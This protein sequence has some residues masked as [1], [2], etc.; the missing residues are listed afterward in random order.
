MWFI[1]FISL[2]SGA[3]VSQTPIP[4]VAGNIAGIADD[5]RAMIACNKFAGI[6]KVIEYH[7]AHISA[8]DRVHSRIVRAE[9][10]KQ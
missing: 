6:T 9:C 5:A 3:V 2:S 10:R 8:W 4:T 7:R 1:V